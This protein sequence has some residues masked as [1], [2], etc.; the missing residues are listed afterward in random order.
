[1]KRKKENGHRVKWVLE[2]GKGGKAKKGSLGIKITRD[3]HW[4]F[5]E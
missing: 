2:T 4:D 1:M 3:W 5:L